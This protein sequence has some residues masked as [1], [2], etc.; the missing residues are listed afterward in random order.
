MKKQRV[1]VIESRWEAGKP[2]H[3]EA[4]R[5]LK[6]M[7]ALDYMGEADLD[8]GGDGDHGETLLYLLSEFLERDGRGRA[9]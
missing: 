8:L 4:V 6:G 3:P 7:K 5:I 2:H 1:S 9:K